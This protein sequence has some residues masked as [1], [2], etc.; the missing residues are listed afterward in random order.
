MDMSTLKTIYSIQPGKVSVAA[1]A[2]WRD[3]LIATLAQ[4]QTPPVLTDYINLSIGGTLS[5]G[6]VNGTTYCEGAQIDNTLELDVITGD[7]NL[8]TC[9][10]TQ[11]R[12]LFQAV[13]GG[14]A[15]A[16]LLSAQP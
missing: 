11:H 6:G 14:L 5:V 7:G 10:G 16:P 13:L 15:N 4:G 9:S 1:G 3:L 12:D 2:K 8:V